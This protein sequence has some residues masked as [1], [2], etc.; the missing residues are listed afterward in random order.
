MFVS[1]KDRHCISTIGDFKSVYL[2]DVV[3]T[4]GRVCFYIINLRWC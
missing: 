2:N 3:L 4:Q 1:A